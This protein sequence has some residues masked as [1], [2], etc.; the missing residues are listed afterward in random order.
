M[1]PSGVDF[2]FFPC[3]L[4]N[5]CSDVSAA[6]IQL[7]GCC[8]GCYPFFSPPS[9]LGLVDVSALYGAQFTVLTSHHV[10]MGCLKIVALLLNFRSWRCIV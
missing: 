6:A 5:F 3:S 10:Q 7:G 1:M 2:F 9:G 8:S 4:L